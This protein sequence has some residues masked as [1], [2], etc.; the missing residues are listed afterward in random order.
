MKEVEIPLEVSIYGKVQN[1][2]IEFSI[3]VDEELTSLPSEQYTIPESFRFKEGQR[4]DTIYIKVR[5][6]EDLTTSSK[7]LV[8]RIKSTNEI[9]AGVEEYSTAVI[10]LSDRLFKPDWWSVLDVFNV[11]NSVD[12]YYL[13]E[14][15]KIKYLMFIEELQKDNIIFDGKDKQILRKYALRLK[16]TLKKINEERASQTPPLPPLTDEYGAI[17][18]IIV[19]G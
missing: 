19:A 1:N 14:Y 16:N 5:N 8:L 13:G 9:E 2:D 11:S 7:H 17:I 12:Q 10:L 6:S 15:S 3:Y 4:T 18:E